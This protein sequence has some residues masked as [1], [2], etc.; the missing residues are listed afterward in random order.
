[1]IN[2]REL[3]RMAELNGA[4]ATVGH[5]SESIEAG[6]LK[7]TDFSLRGLFQ[8]L[9][10]NRDGTIVGNDVLEECCDPRGPR[11]VL[12]ESAHTVDTSHFA[13]VSGLLTVRQAMDAYKAEEFVFSA[14]IPTMSA[15]RQLERLSGTSQ[16]GDQAQIIGESKPYPT[17]G[18]TED[19][20]DL[21]TMLKR[22]FIVPVT[23]EA[24]FF[25]ETAQVLRR[26]SDLGYSFGLNKEKRAIDCVIDENTTAHRYKWRNSTYATYQTSTPWIN[27]KT[28]NALV[29]WTDIDA[30]EAL[31]ANMVD[32]N[33]GEPI[34]VAPN[35]LM[36]APSLEATAMRVLDAIGIAYHSAGYP[37]NA[38][39]LATTA[40]NPIG[41]A[42]SKY[43]MKYSIV[44][45]RQF[46]ARLATDTDWFLNNPAKAWVY[47]EAWPATPSQAPVNSEMEFNNDIAFRFK[48]SE[49][50]AYATVDP[51]Y[52]AKSAA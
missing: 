19:W 20:V 23:K 37:T 1:M 29:D 43:S 35:T 2:N 16:L 34:E 33:T 46:A 51:R 7:P 36:V 22:G 4:E 44:S 18:F 8:A 10:T 9:V 28:S 11:K 40:G 21:P 48:I 26:A 38:A 24:I 15:A 42:G 25:D 45:S 27:S 39:A 49:M 41:R 47:R 50:G 14:L 12:S 6:H 17:A 31:F 5:L 30:V 3:R 32:P 13:N 52:A